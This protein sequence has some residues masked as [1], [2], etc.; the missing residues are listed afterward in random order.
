[1]D[2]LA[3]A[4]ALGTRGADV[5]LVQCLEHGGAGHAGDDGHRVER[6]RDGG[7]HHV[8]QRVAECL[9]VAR[10]QGVQQEE[11]RAADRR[12][13]RVDAA[14]GGQP[15]QD[16]GKEDDHQDARPVDG[17]GHAEQGKDG[18]EAVDR[19]AAVGRGDHAQRDADYGRDDDGDDG[20]LDGGREAAEDFLGDCGVGVVGL[21]QIPVQCPA[22]EAQVLVDERI[23]EA[24]C[25]APR[26]HLLLGGV[27]TED[28]GCRVRGEDAHDQKHDD[29]DAKDDQDGLEDSLDDVLCHGRDLLSCLALRSCRMST[30]RSLSHA[31]LSL[32]EG[33]KQAS[34]PADESDRPGRRLYTRA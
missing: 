9:K 25:L 11:A 27:L 10:Q 4:Q 16:A 30:A 14:R 20:Q 7:Q 31:G 34:G 6:E 28:H 24:V 19:G 2:D 12:Q 22:D 26:L 1:M 8:G 33:R 5:V 32:K 18:G 23:V 21:A 29:R 3:L 13:Q 17:H 15:A